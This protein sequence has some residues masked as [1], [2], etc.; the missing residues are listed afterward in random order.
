MMEALRAEFDNVSEIAAES[1]FSVVD[2]LGVLVRRDTVRDR[3]Q[4]VVP[5]SLRE[6]GNR[7]MSI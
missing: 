6:V 7:Y 1:D 4:T 5:P 2:Q 3:S